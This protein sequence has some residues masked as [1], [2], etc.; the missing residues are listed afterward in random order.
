[1]LL[2][3]IALYLASAS[4]RRHDILNQ[5]HVKH[6]V[7]LVPSP[8][9]EDEPQRPAESPLDYVQ[10]TAME[11]LQLAMQWYQQVHEAG[12][13]AA[14][15]TADTTVALDGRILGKPADLH[16]AARFLDALSNTTHR[17]LTAVCLGY[18]STVLRAL[19]ISEVQFKALSP[20]E[21]DWYCRTGEPLG[22]AGGYAIQGAGGMFVQQ[23]RGSHSGVAGL[24][25]HETYAL[26]Q[27]A[28]L[29]DL[30]VSVEQNQSEY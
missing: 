11:K 22:K 5:M 17:V 26:L 6:E 23:L 24:P 4:P 28:R 16:E 20:A 27:Q 21:I 13:K 8:P 18:G 15:L 10:R 12:Q 7:L 3:S 30:S 2:N 25:M 29:I 14:I 1:M 9:G 19:S